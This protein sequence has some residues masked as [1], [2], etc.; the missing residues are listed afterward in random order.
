MNLQV[1]TLENG[2]RVIS[3]PMPNLETS[4][5]GVWVDTGARHETPE[6]NG[7]SHVLEHMAFKGTETRS[8]YDIAESIEAVGGHLNAYTSRDQTAYYARVLKDDLGLATEILSDI[9][10]HSTFDQDELAREKEVIVQEIGQ[11]NDTPDDIIFDHLQETAYA[12]QAVG[13]SILGTAERVR[14]FTRET[15]SGYMKDRY[16]APQLVLSASGAVDHDELVRMAEDMF[17]GLAK[18]GQTGMEDARYTGGDYREARDLEQVHFALSVPGLSYQDEDFYAV[19][20]LSGLLGGG[21]SSRLFQEVREKRGLCY[22]VFAFSSSFADAGLFTV[23]AGTGAEQIGEL[24]GVIC[25]E[26]IRATSDITEA[27]VARARAQHKAALLMGQESPAARCEV[28][29]RQMLIYDRVIS[30]Q[31]I[32]EKIEAVTPEH[33]Q[34][35]AKRLFCNVSPTIAGLGPI[36]NLDKFDHFAARFA[37]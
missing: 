1:S 11:T 3:D 29:A 15:V 8:A 2:M 27:E 14:G 7:I 5:V 22:S 32:S 19:Q 26:L 24:G 12:N 6:Q 23:Y 37:G 35:V 18:E 10:Q 31:E 16:L 9:L 4:A 36:K 30:P 20:V 21:M 28:H 13:R 34:K 25:D 17:S 33:L